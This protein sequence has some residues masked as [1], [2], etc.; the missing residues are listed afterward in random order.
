VNP[1]TY[2]WSWGTGERADTFRL[3]V[4][5]IG[6]PAVPEP[7]TW[8]MMALGFAGLGYAAIRRKTLTNANSA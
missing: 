3:T 5:P 7:S 2:V 8:A 4:L 6:S 1:G